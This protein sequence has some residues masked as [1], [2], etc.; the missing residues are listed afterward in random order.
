MI[1]P[2]ADGGSFNPTLGGAK[3]PG[4]VPS[5]G[6]PAWKKNL[7][8]ILGSIQSP[9]QPEEDLPA[10][11]LPNQGIMTKPQQFQ[12]PMMSQMP[13]RRYPPISPQGYGGGY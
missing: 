2:Y 13:M 8:G 11:Q 10:M 1:N 7:A 12:Q 4:D 5:I 6:L 9:Q 3:G